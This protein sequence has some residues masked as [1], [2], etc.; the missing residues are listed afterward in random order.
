MKLAANTTLFNI[1]D[2]MKTRWKELKKKQ[3]RLFAKIPTNGIIDKEEERSDHFA[4]GLNIYKLLIICIV[5]SFAGVII[6]MI[7][8]LI[9][10]GYIE[11]RAGLVYGPFNL[12]YGVGA[13]LLTLCL[14]RFRNRGAWIS[15]LGGMSMF[16]LSYKK[17][18]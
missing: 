9:R 8:C 1:T 11:S 3:K 6:E 17:C 12:L 2:E 15:F 10:N 18:L 7:W 16:V 4:K 5:G 14:Y 13:V